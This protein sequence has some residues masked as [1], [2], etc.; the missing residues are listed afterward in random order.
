MPKPPFIGKPGDPADR[1][2]HAVTF[3]ELN[4]AERMAL[5][6]LT[7]V[8]L[9]ADANI[10]ESEVARLDEIVH[11]VGEETFRALTDEAEHRFADRQTVRVFLQTIT[12]Q[13]A[14]E[15]IYGTVLAEALTDTMP[16]TE[17]EFLD[18]LAQAWN[19]TLKVEEP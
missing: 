1:K 8:A 11:E 2:E 10:S 16:H 18:W 12:R 19:I 6:A 15:L 5:V 4:D 3:S 13:E 14:R 17:S 9:R 7:E